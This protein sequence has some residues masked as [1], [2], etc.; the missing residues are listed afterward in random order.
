MN[1]P[2]AVAYRP[3]R[4][5]GW[6]GKQILGHLLDS[7]ANN[8][9]RFVRGRIDGSYTGPEYAQEAWVAAHGYEQQ[10]WST[11]LRWWDVEHEMLAAVVSGIPEERLGAMCVVG[12]NAPVTLGF[13]ITDYVRHQRWHLA[14]LDIAAAALQEQGE[15]ARFDRPSGSS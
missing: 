15:S 7:A 9:Q 11:L 10:E 6:T 5:G 3:W 14:Q 12:G 13:L 1:L 8:R 2:A 4:A